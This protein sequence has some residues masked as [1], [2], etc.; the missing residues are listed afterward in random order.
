MYESPR[1]VVLL[2]VGLLAGA[3]VAV[4]AAVLRWPSPVVLV[5]TVF[6]FLLVGVPVAVPDKALSGVL[7]TTDGLLDLVS[8]V[9]LGWRQ[10]LTIS[11]PVGDYQ[12][13]L[14]PALVLVLVGTAVALSLAL[15]A[16]RPEL[17]ALVPTGRVRHRHRVR[18]GSAGAPHRGADRAPG[19]G[20]ALARVVALAAQ[21]RGRPG[22]LGGFRCARTGL[23]RGRR[24]LA[25]RSS[26]DPRR[27][28]GV[29]GGCG[30]R[31]STVGGAHGAPH[32]DADP[33]RPAI[34]REPALRGSGRSG[35]TRSRMS[36]C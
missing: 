3:L 8:G 22:A 24:A 33:V 19:C 34:G 32:H 28:L 18:T 2:A 21:G 1:F 27:G 6:V 17:A 31:A 12:A 10:L 13:L 5:L 20:A 36:C 35:R 26:G 14:V 9:A 11:I 15:R 30:D 7:P 29:R 25:A 23:C 4:P 16:R